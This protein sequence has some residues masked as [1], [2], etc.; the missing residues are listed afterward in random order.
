[1]AVGLLT[2]AE[3]LLRTHSPASFKSGGDPFAFAECI[4]I[5]RAVEDEEAWTPAY[6]SLDAF[7][8]EHEDRHPDVRLYG[9]ARRE[10]LHADLSSPAE[11]PA[12][13]LQR[14]RR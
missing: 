4:E 8:A 11:T 13:I 14:L 9:A 2:E 3:R 1:M 5:V 7:Y 6:P 10:I 12:Q